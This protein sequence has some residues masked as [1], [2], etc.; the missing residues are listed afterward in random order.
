MHEAHE[1]NARQKANRAVVAV[2]DVV[3]RFLLED[4]ETYPEVTSLVKGMELMHWMLFG[5]DIEPG[6]WAA[7]GVMHDLNAG[8]Q[9]YRVGEKITGFESS[10]YFINQRLT[11]RIAELK[12][13]E[14]PAAMEDDPFD[15]FSSNGSGQN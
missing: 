5:P 11:R 8:K 10:R 14:S 4:T 12:V 3:K 2:E 13:D 1:T 6:W 7:V 15:V 9:G